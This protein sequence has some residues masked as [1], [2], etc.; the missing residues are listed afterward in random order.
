MVSHSLTSP[1]SEKTSGDLLKVTEEG[2]VKVVSS[3]HSVLCHVAVLQLR[4]TR[5]MVR[6]LMFFALSLWQY[7]PLFLVAMSLVSKYAVQP[8]SISLAGIAPLPIYRPYRYCT[9]TIEAENI[10]PVSSQILSQQVNKNP[11]R[12]HRETR[13]T[14][15]LPDIRAC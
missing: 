5:V 12:E 15:Y 2:G 6:L 1:S 8:T 3:C 7:S 11:Q 9:R 10:Q 4:M 13:V 14:R